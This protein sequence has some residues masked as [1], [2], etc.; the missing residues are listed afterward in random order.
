[1][2][3]RATKTQKGLTGKQKIFIRK[4]VQLGEGKKAAILAGYSE[5]SA[6]V[7]ASRLLTNAKVQSEINRMNKIIEEKTA[8]TQATLVKDAEFLKQKALHGEPVYDDDGQLIDL[9]GQDDKNALASIQTQARLLGI[10]GFG[11]TDV[12]IDA[13]TQIQNNFQYNINVLTSDEKKT[14]LFY[15]VCRQ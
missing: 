6:E 10:G 11:K 15:S 5:D 14:S 9:V 3:Q 4:Y 7:T 13:R 12:K 1:M 8:I 2:P